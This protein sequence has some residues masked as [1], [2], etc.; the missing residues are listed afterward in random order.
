MT[1]RSMG[2]GQDDVNEV[3]KRAVFNIVGRN[4][5]DHTKNFGFLM[6]KKGVWKLS[7]A[8]DLTYA[9]DP[10]GK[11]TKVHQIKLNRKQ[12]NFTEK[13]IVAFGKYCNITEKTSLDILKNTI[14]EFLK[15]EDL[16]TQYDVSKSLKDTVL[17][18]LRLKF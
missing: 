18:N 11:W 17:G 3:F 10:H 7:P 5:D 15:F 13:D 2:L 14:S 9:Y 16:A 6:N 12:D 4:Q 1:M 8:F